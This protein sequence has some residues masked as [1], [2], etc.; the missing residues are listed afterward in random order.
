MMSSARPIYRTEAV[1]H[2]LLGREH[3]VLPRLTSPRALKILWGVVGLLLAVGV[4]GWFVDVPLHVSGA[5]VIVDASEV[6]HAGS[7][8]IVVA[9]FPPEY[10]G[11]VHLGQAMVVDLGGS[12]GRLTGSVTAVESTRR[13]PAGGGISLPRPITDALSRLSL[14]A[15]GSLDALPASLAESGGVQGAYAVQI[16]L[17]TRPVL[18][19]V[20]GFGDVAEMGR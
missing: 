9:F 6:G 3:A 12:N 11:Q 7:G 1:R 20:P 8:R 14:V 13:G 4:S 19:L 16:R 18:A 10:R 15:I 17:G 2:H 5:A